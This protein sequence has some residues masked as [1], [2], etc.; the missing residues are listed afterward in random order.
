[1]FTITSSGPILL[2]DMEVSAAAVSIP[3]P[4]AI[5]VLGAAGLLALR[6]RR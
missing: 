6:R 2:V 1:V 4:G 3:A 5:G